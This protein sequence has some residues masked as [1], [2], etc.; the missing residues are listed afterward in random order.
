MI[1]PSL[2]NQLTQLGDRIVQVGDDSVIGNIKDRGVGVLVNGNDDLAVLDAG[3][4]LSRTGDA[5]R[6]IKVGGNDFAGLADLKLVWG[7]AAVDGGSSCS[8]GAAQRIGKPAN[9]AF[10]G[11]GIL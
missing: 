5:S 1:R 9:Y 11:G 6:N 8:S 3:H 2:P 10:V 7:D 4:V